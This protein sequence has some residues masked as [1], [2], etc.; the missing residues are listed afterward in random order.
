MKKKEIPKREIPFEEGIIVSAFKYKT[1]PCTVLTAENHQGEATHY[2]GYVRIKEEDVEKIGRGRE[3]EEVYTNIIDIHGGI[4]YG[5][6]A[7]GWIG[8]DCAHLD[9]FCYDESGCVLPGREQPSTKYPDETSYTKWYI[10]DVEDE[11]KSAVDFFTKESEWYC[12][13]CGVETLFDQYESVN[14]CPVCE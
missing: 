12:E 8:F 13:R 1:Y 5:P 6:D 7:H 4:T 9:D 10:E 11:L 3:G 14:Y 2:C